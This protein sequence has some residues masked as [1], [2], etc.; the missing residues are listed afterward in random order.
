MKSKDENLLDGGKDGGEDV[1]LGGGEGNVFGVWQQ[2][3]RLTKQDE[4]S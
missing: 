3:D 1:G 4:K 2:M